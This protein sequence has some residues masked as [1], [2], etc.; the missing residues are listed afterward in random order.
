MGNRIPW[1][2]KTL[3]SFGL[4]FWAPEPQLLFVLPLVWSLD[5]GGYGPSTPSYSH[6]PSK[7]GD[8]SVTELRV[9]MTF[10]Q[11]F[12]SVF[13]PACSFTQDGSC[14]RYGG[15]GDSNEPLERTGHSGLGV[16]VS[17]S[18]LVCL[19]DPQVRMGLGLSV[20]LSVWGVSVCECDHI[21]H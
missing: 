8:G 7:P 13:P 19:L 14:M 11:A 18:L 16:D 2:T 17:A 5:G 15:R 4:G 12:L 1:E 20:C 10:V 6:W 3:S 9:E 21:P